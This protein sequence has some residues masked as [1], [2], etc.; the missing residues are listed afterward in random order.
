M[1]IGYHDRASDSDTPILAEI[2]TLQAESLGQLVQSVRGDIITPD[3]WIKVIATLLAQLG[4]FKR[5]T[6]AVLILCIAFF[7]TVN[8][9][10]NSTFA[11]QWVNAAM[12]VVSFYL[13]SHTTAQATAA[14]TTKT[15]EDQGEDGTTGGTI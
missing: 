12:L 8:P 15:G 13:G 3:E 4:Q 5:I 1:K 6:I 2:R 9:S 10:V 11:G 7:V 14:T